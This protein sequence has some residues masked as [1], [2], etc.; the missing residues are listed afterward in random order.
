M[1][2]KKAEEK[3]FRKGLRVDATVGNIKAEENTNRKTLHNNCMPDG[4]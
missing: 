1:N 4:D 3:P 2:I